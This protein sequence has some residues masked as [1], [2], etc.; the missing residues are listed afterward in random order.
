MA[1]AVRSLPGRHRA[2]A[3]ADGSA[4]LPAAPA[5]VAAVALL[6]TAGTASSPRPRVTKRVSTVPTSGRVSPT[7]AGE[8]RFGRG[9]RP[10]RQTSP[11]TLRPTARFSRARHHAPG[12]R[13]ARRAPPREGVPLGPTPGMAARPVQWGIWRPPTSGLTSEPRRARQRCRWAKRAAAA[14]VVAGRQATDQVLRRPRASHGRL[15][16]GIVTAASVAAAAAATHRPPAGRHVPSGQGSHAGRGTAGGQTR[17]CCGGGGCH[18]RG[19]GTRHA[20]VWQAEQQCGRTKSGSGTQ[21][22]RCRGGRR[23]HWEAR[24]SLAVH[25]WPSRALC[26]QIGRDTSAV[27]LTVFYWSR[28]SWRPRLQSVMCQSRFRSN[29]I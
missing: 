19:R 26:G 27:V 14:V 7:A 11:V 21:Q 17:G 13:R 12:R 1:I 6:A 16:C 3:A 8:G 28:R 23:T 25:V 9:G 4:L 5:R 29:H 22:P 24:P 10:N 2:R 20:R 18:G 15:R